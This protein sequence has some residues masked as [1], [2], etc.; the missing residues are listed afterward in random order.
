MNILINGMAFIVQSVG[1]GSRRHTEEALGYAR[2]RLRDDPTADLDKVA[3]DAATELGCL[4]GSFILRPANLEMGVIGA[5][6]AAL[7]ARPSSD[8]R[9]MTAKDVT[10]RLGLK[11]D[12]GTCRKVGAALRRHL[13]DPRT[14]NG[15]TVWDVPD[16]WYANGGT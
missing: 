9:R 10:R 6:V 11:L 12:I 5:R 15:H 3:V 13:G 4:R 8:Y 16:V 14:S 1:W 7:L 2:Q